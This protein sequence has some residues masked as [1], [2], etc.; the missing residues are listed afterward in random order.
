MLVAEAGASKKSFAILRAVGATQAQLSARLAWRAVRTALVGIAI[1]LPVGAL[2]GWLFTL[3][4]G[5]WPGIPHYF[6][7]PFPVVAEGALGALLF[8]LIV[9]VPTSMSLVRRASRC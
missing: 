8:A 6:V 5:N 7:L 1:G 9:A 3:K 4:T 2:A